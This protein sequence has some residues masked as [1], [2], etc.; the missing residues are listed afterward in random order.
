M[1]TIRLTHKE[2][3]LSLY[4]VPQCVILNTSGY[5]KVLDMGID[6]G[7]MVELFYTFTPL[8]G[9]GRTTTWHTEGFLDGGVIEF[10][11][12]ITAEYHPVTGKD[13]ITLTV[14]N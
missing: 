9:D 8:T 11:G 5:E 13:E 12:C 7:E 3:I 14:T 6:Q 1:K 10:R 4:R 2:G